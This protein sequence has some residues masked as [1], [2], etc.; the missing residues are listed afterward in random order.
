MDI[1]MPTVSISSNA[2]LESQ[3]RRVSLQVTDWFREN[4]SDPHHV[5]VHFHE[6]PVMYYFVGGIPMLGKRANTHPVDSDFQWASILC[7]V[8]QHRTREYLQGLSQF[9]WKTLGAEGMIHFVCRFN[10]VDPRETHYA[11]SGTLVVTEQAEK[12]LQ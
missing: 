7:T 11:D 10:L 1:N 2:V 3:R 9:L 8:G 6:I 12:E 4:G 5:I